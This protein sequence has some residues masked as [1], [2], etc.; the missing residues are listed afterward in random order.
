MPDASYAAPAA[1]PAKIE[2][3]ATWVLAAASSDFYEH[4]NEVCAAHGIEVRSEW[5]RTAH[6]FVR[7]ES[8]E[9]F[10]YKEF[11]QIWRQSKRPEGLVVFP[12]TSVPGVILSVLEQRVNV[13]DDLRLVAHKH[14][15]INFLCPLPITYLYSSTGTGPY[16]D[17][18][19]PIT[20]TEWW[21]M[22]QEDVRELTKRG[23]PGVWTYGFYDG[24]TPNYM[25]FVAHTKNAIGR[26]Y[27]V[28]SYGP[29]NYEVRPPATTTSREWFRP[30]PPLPYIKRIPGLDYEP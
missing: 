6:G 30:N 3:P 11:R 24:W 18:I 29:D 9:E 10:G 23:V 21:T 16:N 26:F 4:F 28:Q 14:A 17:A 12:D 27:E 15:E 25:F 5:I 8:Q 22:A 2:R 19:D 1:V 13:P 7:D 20:V